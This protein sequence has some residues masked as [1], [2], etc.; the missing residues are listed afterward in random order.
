MG[1][2]AG[3][4]DLVLVQ[5]IAYTF[6]ASSQGT[7]DDT[8]A[9]NS[10][11]SDGAMSCENAEARLESQTYNY[12]M[13]PQNARS[14]SCNYTH[15]NSSQQQVWLLPFTEVLSKRRQFACDSLGRIHVIIGKTFQGCIVL[16]AINVHGF[17][18][19]K[20]STGFVA[21]CCVFHVK[22]CSTE[23]VHWQAP[24]LAFTSKWFVAIA[25]VIVEYA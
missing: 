23:H 9:S 21:I 6:P 7:F 22:Y 3:L 14:D 15:S 8:T 17:V 4:E 12:A 24:Y 2:V 1:H 5:N 11:N 10:R 13:G 25:R 19:K 20:V 16:F 18:L